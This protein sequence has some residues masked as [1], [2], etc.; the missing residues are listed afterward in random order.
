M[1]TDFLKNDGL[2]Y[3]KASHYPGLSDC[4]FDFLKYFTG[5]QASAGAVV[6]TKN[7]NSV[8]VDG[9]YEL[10]AKLS[11]DSDNCE[12]NSLSIKGIVSW[13]KNN[14]SKSSN[15]LV[16]ARFFSH[17]TIRFIQSELLDYKF[18]PQ[19]FDALFD[20]PIINRESQ[21][22]SIPGKQQDKK[23]EFIYN[24]IDEHR[25]DAYL[26]CDPCS[27]AWLLNIR[28]LKTQNTPV[29]LC[30][31]LITKH[32]EKYL[33]V[34]KS[35]LDMPY[36][37]IS[38]LKNDLNDY[39]SVGADFKEVPYSIQHHN[40]INIKNPIP[41]IKSIKS[42]EELR[43]IKQAALQDSA[44][45]I[46]FIR[47]FDETLGTITEIE[48][49]RKILEFRQRMP[50]FIGNSF[51]TI[52]AADENA[53]IVHYAP[54]QDNDKTVNNI[55]LLDSGG[56][57]KYGTTDITRTIARKEPKA[58]EKLCYTLVLKGH[59]A[60]AQAK[61]PKGNS[62]A[63]LDAL[64]RQFLLNYNLDYGHSTGH[65]IGYMLGVHEGPIAISKYNSVEL[66]SNMVLSNEPGV[67]MEGSIGVRLENMM[68]SKRE[69]DY[70]V[71]DTVSLVPFDYKFI[72]FSLLNGNEKLWLNEYHKMITNNEFLEKDT[73]NWL[74]LH[75]K[76][77]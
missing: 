34:D 41:A 16:D 37:T 45:I 36:P 25:L 5:M 47:W 51:G 4:G 74:S 23:L 20:I 19:D 27:I 72:D 58:R 52:A 56:Q 8:F 44:A 9:R 49:V 32:R 46:N 43:H 26:V 54:S 3:I 38:K 6:L 14:L 62:A 64:A 61:I 12:I 13:I 53:A 67:Y 15:I 18:I 76:E 77:F 21:I 63:I 31:L 69:G 10:A 55:L 65:G 7:R 70:I 59:L 73:I 1:N 66:Q 2:L 11:I 68:V 75:I 22:I 28:D 60:V 42:D 30:Y 35:Y 39:S 29:L 57:Y 17:E 50:D 33:Y 40:L 48:C 24:L 71:F